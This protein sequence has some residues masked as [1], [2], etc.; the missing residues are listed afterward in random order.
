MGEFQ[1]Y[2]ILYDNWLLLTLFL[3]PPKKSEEEKEN[4]AAKPVL[5]HKGYGFL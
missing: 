2:P 1:I 3:F 5:N 4:E